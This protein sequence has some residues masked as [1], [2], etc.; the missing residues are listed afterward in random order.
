MIFLSRQKIQKF[1]TR[2]F[3]CDASSFNVAKTHILT[4]LNNNRESYRNQWYY[5]SGKVCNLAIF[6]ELASQK[7]FRV[8]SFCIFF[9]VRNVENNVHVNSFDVWAILE[10]NS[11]WKTSKTHHLFIQKHGF[12]CQNMVSFVRTSLSKS[13]AAA[14]LTAGRRNDSS[15][16]GMIFYGELHSF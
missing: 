6:N 16:L 13:S 15:R 14:I 1:S 10:T 3:F 5:R 12:P 8:E 2:K 7:N 4:T 9:L 11:K